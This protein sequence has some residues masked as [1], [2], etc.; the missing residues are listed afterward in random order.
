M[1]GLQARFR[2]RYGQFELDAEISVPAK[3]VTALFGASGSGKTTV[4]R[5]IA[6]L[7]RAPVGYLEVDGETWQDEARGHF[8]PPHRRACA[9]VFQEANL[10][11][12]LTVLQNLEYGFRRVPAEKRRVAFEETVATLDLA[13]LLGRRPHGLSGGERQRVAIGRAVLSSPRLLL[14]DEPIASL[15]TARKGEVLYYIE[16]LRDQ[17]G[18]PIFYV[19]HA[20]DEVVRLADTMA[21]LSEGRVLACGSVTALASRLDLRPHLGRFEAGTV[22]EATVAGHDLEHGLATLRFDGGELQAPDVQSLVGEQ[23]RVRIRAR[24][25]SVALSAPRDASFLNVLPG[26]VKEIGSMEGAGVDVA[27]AVGSATVV[28]RITRKSVHALALAPGKPVYALVKSV[29]IDRHSV[30][31]A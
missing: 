24:D 7:T 29:A 21:V 31:Y 19:S 16:R 10:F 22:V 17:V 2:L 6:G 20:I 8:V 3:G 1:N 18:I 28:A 23:L 14:M 11:P 27:I 12:H 4:L 26:I 13:P 30:G 9:Y 15:D 5:C 25:V